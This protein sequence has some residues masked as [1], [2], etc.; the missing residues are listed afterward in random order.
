MY[1]SIPHM[2]TTYMQSFII[3]H[4]ACAEQYGDMSADTQAHTYTHS[5][6]NKLPTAGVQLV[7]HT[8]IIN[9]STGK[10]QSYI[11]IICL[12]HDPQEDKL[13]HL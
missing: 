11:Q 1:R 2:Q 5:H 9:M 10:Y 8:S 12:T 6:T 7:C 4:S 13:Y 3:S